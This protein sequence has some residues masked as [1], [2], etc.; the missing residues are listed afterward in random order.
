MPAKAEM[1]VAVV[2]P[3]HGHFDYAARAVTSL[4]EHTAPGVITPAWSTMP[5][6][7]GRQTKT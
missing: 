1:R 7:T 6:P 4:F 2:I 5:V 3:T